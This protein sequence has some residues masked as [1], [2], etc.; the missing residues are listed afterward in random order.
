MPF[1]I[2]IFLLHWLAYLLICHQNAPLVGRGITFEGLLAD[3]RDRPPLRALDVTWE[4]A[5]P[6]SIGEVRSVGTKVVVPL[7][8]IVALVKIIRVQLSRIDLLVEHVVWRVLLHML[9]LFT[10]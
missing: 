5:R 6:V 4:D 8:V 9:R 2:L 1:S 7:K 3:R 10:H